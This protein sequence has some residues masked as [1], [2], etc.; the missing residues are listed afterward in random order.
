MTAVEFE[1]RLIALE[2]EA[3]R[4]GLSADD[5]VSAYEL[6]RMAVLEAEPDED[7]T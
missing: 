1:D 5:I 2:A 4:A 3:E 6:R 7:A